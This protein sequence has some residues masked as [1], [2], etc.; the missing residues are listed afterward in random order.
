MAYSESGQ[1]LSAVHGRIRGGRVELQMESP[2]EEKQE[3]GDRM[4]RGVRKTREG[5]SV[6]PPQED[7]WSGLCHQRDWR[8]CGTLAWTVT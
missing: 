6:E 3:A 7:F 4:K 1:K 5:G 8:L 2:V